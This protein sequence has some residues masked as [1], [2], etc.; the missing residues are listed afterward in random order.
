[1][2][3]LSGF[4]LMLM[5]VSGNITDFQLFPFSEYPVHVQPSGS[6]TDFQLFPF[7]EYPIHVQPSGSINIKKYKCYH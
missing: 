3:V 2:S 7:S 6:I 1:M 4:I 5:C